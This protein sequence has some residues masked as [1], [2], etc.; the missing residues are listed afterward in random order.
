VSNVFDSNL[1]RTS[2]DIKNGS[3]VLQGAAYAYD[4]AGRLQTVTDNSATAYTVTY[5]YEPNSSLVSSITAKSNSTVRLA[6][7]KVYDKLNRLQSISSTNSTL[8]SPISFSYENNSANQRTKM[9]HE[10]GHIGFMST[11]V[12]ARSS[13]GKNTGLMEPQLTANNLNTRTTISETERPPGAGLPR[14]AHTQ[15]IG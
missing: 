5:A 6:T 14:K 9:T 2:V 10:D 13:P 11:T 15:Q 7:T 8:P 3:S 1:R 12:W 4:A